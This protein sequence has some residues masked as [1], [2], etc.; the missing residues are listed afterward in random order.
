M[1]D[2]D[3]AQE[4]VDTVRLQVAGAQ[5]Q[6]VGK[7]AARLTKE[8][9]RE[10]GVE[11]GDIIEVTGK[12]NTAV[13]ALPPY[14]EDEGL[15]IIRLDGLQRANAGVG[16]GD[17]VEVSQADVKPAERVTLAPAQQ[18]LRITGSGQ[19]LLRTLF[20]RPLVT[21]DVISTSVYRRTP[22]MD[23]G[24][25]PEDIFRQFFQQRAFGLQEIRLVVTSTTP[26]GTVQVTQDTEIE[27][28]EQ[29]AEPHISHAILRRHVAHGVLPQPDGGTM[30]SDWPDLFQLNDDERADEDTTIQSTV[31]VAITKTV[32]DP[33]PVQGDLLT[34]TLD[35]V[36]NG[37][38]D[39]TTVTV[40]DTLPAE[41]T[42]AGFVPGTLPCS[43]AG[44][45]LTCTF[46][47]L[48]AGD[49]VVIGIEATVNA[50]A[51]TATQPITNT[52]PN[53]GAQGIFYGNVYLYGQRG[54]QA[55]ELIGAYLERQ[56][57]R[58]GS[59][60]LQ[61]VYQQ[62]AS[63]DV[64]AISLEQVYTQLATTELVERERYE[65]EALQSFDAE[66]FIRERDP[67]SSL[68]GRARIAVN[69]DSK[70][71]AEWTAKA[72]GRFDS[73]LL[74]IHDKHLLQ[75]I[76]EGVRVAFEGSPLVTEAITQH[77]QLVLLGEPGSGKVRRMTARVIARNAPQV[78]AMTCEVDRLTGGGN[79]YGNTACR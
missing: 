54:K 60:P 75:T 63:D 40:T 51:S 52:A 71:A 30:E 26:R 2:R 76:H 5:K 23:G 22:G 46:P 1:A 42:P 13:I 58:C 64:L 68:P 72:T 73:A 28:Q 49:N 32:N 10:L 18:N 47:T 29:Y 57:R 7:G 35:V 9:L 6:D 24:P 70:Q 50:S 59:L 66:A 74:H 17:H 11:P 19:A 48:A 12:K 20:R 77:Q 4:G 15:S 37:P 34:Y 62:K 8:T 61:G 79:T 27:L 45:T 16:L 33:T 41:L 31:D 39:A 69:I 25:F 21:G 36:N 56:V 44:Q 38:A 67:D 55:S 78:G 14:P 53:Q 43:F 3:V 65:G